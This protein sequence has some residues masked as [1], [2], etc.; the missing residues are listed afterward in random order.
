MNLR[1][2]YLTFILLTSTVFSTGLKA[3]SV[4]LTFGSTGNGFESYSIDLSQDAKKVIVSNDGGLYV[5][6]DVGMID[7]IGYNQD[8][9]VMKLD[10]DGQLQTSFGNAGIVRADFATID[11]SRA[12]DLE[13]DSNGNLYVLGSG[14]SRKGYA[15]APTC[16]VRLTSAGIPDS[17]FGTNGEVTTFVEGW[18][19]YPNDIELDSLERIWIAG[20]TD[21]SLG[22]ISA[23]YL[24]RLQTNG[25]YDTTWATNGAYTKE[26][27]VNEPF[28][29][30]N[31]RNGRHSTGR[32][33]YGIKIIGSAI[34]TTG[35]DNSYR[36]IV[37]KFDM[38]AGLDTLFADAGH[39]TFVHPLNE[40]MFFQSIELIDRTLVLEIFLYGNN[41]RD[42]EYASFNL[43]SNK[44]VHQRVVYADD[45]VF[46]SFAV[47][48]SNL[49]IIGRNIFA[50]NI[51]PAYYADQFMITKIGPDLDLVDDFGDEGNFNF[52]YNSGVNQAGGVFGIFADDTT[53]YIAGNVIDTNTFS[54]L[55]L[56]RV[57]IPSSC[58]IPIIDTTN[59][60]S[61]AVNL[62]RSFMV[63]PNPSSGNVSILN[64]SKEPM[65]LEL[66]QVFDATGRLCF[67]VSNPK[68]PFFDLS[69][70]D[71]GTY[72]LVVYGKEHFFSEKLLIRR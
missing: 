41:A 26:I 49:F 53:M 29:L 38:N 43:D 19:D 12:T 2:I 32:E 46:G 48:D 6:A 33:Y 58:A 21:D 64:K 28:H 55:L 59:S 9:V 56:T 22:L 37:S 70:L 35:S 7:S 30:N 66:I 52:E 15:Y 40:N 42:F 20:G 63:Y 68:D 67:E 17:S 62:S 65:L 60:I 18:Q 4:D 34:Y 8:W 16:L 71:S 57:K 11:F 39:A 24:L 61:E 14:Y 3:Q 27:A 72:E 50:F 51:H 25:A 54:H 44:Y 69:F 47:N 36:G 1:Q 10:A 45:E 23:S 31:S 5:L 13:E